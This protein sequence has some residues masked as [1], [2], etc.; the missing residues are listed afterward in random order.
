MGVWWYHD[1]DKINLKCD[2]VEN[3]LTLFKP[4]LK[5]E[6]FSHCNQ[7]WMSN[8]KKSIEINTFRGMEFGGNVLAWTDLIVLLCGTE[9]REVSTVAE[10]KSA[11][12]T[13]HLI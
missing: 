6:L 4:W 13:K 2:M 8:F 1:L 7:E 12:N 9:T 10:A 11:M 3:Y 5:R